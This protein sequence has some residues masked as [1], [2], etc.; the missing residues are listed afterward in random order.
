LF[1]GSLMNYLEKIS[2]DLK[3]A[4]KAKDQKRVN[5]LRLLIAP[6][7]DARI[8]LQEDLT[9]EQELSVLMSAAKKRKEAIEFYEQ[10]DRTDLLE[11]E[12]Q[13][14]AIISEYLPEQ[15]SDEETEKIVTE[16]IEKTGAATLKDMGKVMSEAMKSLKGKADG[17]KVQE[18]VRRKLA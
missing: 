10:S 7:K 1:K 8:N 12:Q 2:T 14:L 15:I 3:V 6:L 13:E 17:K 16:I 5:T 4:M 18:I 11:K 9:P